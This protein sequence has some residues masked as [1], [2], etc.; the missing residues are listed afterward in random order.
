MKLYPEYCYTGN[1]SPA[2]IAIATLLAKPCL[3]GIKLRPEER[4]QIAIVDE[5][6]KLSKQDK[7][8]CFFYHSANEG[9]RSRI[10]GAILKAMGLIP[11]KPDLSFHWRTGSG[12]MEVKFGQGRL[13][14]DQKRCKLWCEAMGV[15]HHVTRSL[16]DALETLR[17]WGA[18]T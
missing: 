2:Q 8:R 11:G 1:L 12:V 17:F 14:P 18:I 4:L 6:R 15:R 10:I 9:L 5:L 3:N 7:L 13:S 16:E